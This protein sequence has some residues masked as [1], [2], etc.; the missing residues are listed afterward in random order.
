[1]CDFYKIYLGESENEIN[2]WEKQQIRKGVTGAHLVNVQQESLYSGFVMENQISH[3]KYNS[4]TR[5]TALLLQE[6]YAKNV[7]DNSCK[8]FSSQK[9]PK[10]KSKAKAFKTS[11]EIQLN[12]RERLESLREYNLKHL[13]LM[14]DMC[15]QL[16]N[17]QLVENNW[18]EKAPVVAAKYTFYQETKCYISDLI[19]CINEKVCIISW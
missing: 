16:Q 18:E 14:E 8:L 5:S 2:E 1:L 19:D 7:V 11:Q 10:K 17:A 12:I 3:S 15:Q 4:R 6:A 9:L 13:Q